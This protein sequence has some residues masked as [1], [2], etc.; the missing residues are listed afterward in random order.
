MFRFTIRELVMLTV[1]VALGAGW[2]MEHWKLERTADQLKASDHQ[3]NVHVGLTRTYE[4]LLD[5]KVPNWREDWANEI[6]ARNW[7]VQPS[8]AP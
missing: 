8:W 2:F 6:A 7:P 4:E 5:V 1:I 3:V